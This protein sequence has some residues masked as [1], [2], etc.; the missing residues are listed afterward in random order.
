MVIWF[1]P[2]EVSLGELSVLW[3]CTALHH[4]WADVNRQ[5]DWPMTDCSSLCSS[6]RKPGKIYCC[7]SAFPA[8]ISI[9]CSVIPSPTIF[10]P[11]EFVI[12]IK[13]THIFSLKI[14]SSLMLLPELHQFQ[15]HFLHFSFFLS[16]S[17]LCITFYFALFLFLSLRVFIPVSFLS[18]LQSPLHPPLPSL[19]T[20]HRSAAFSITPRPSPDESQVIGVVNLFTQ[21]QFTAH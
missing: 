3:W 6:R 7:S 20:M 19:G 13:W 11:P 10:F 17:S 21:R 4:R 12:R 9:T 8:L 5:S 15:A 16:P 1:R 2:L 14:T 18:P